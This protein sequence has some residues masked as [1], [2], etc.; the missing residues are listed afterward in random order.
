MRFLPI[1]FVA[2]I[3][4][5]TCA[6]QSSDQLWGQRETLAKELGQQL[7]E[8]KK[9]C[10][11][12]RADAS[13]AE[14]LAIKRD[15]QRQYIFLPTETGLKSDPSPAEAKL[16][17]IRKSHAVKLF[18]LAKKQS[19]AKNA[20][21][22]Y[23]LLHEAL[24]FDP[25]HAE[26]RKILG[27]RK[28]T[29][30]KTNWNVSSD[31]LRLRKS[32]RENSEFKWPKKSYWLASTAHFEITSRA[33]EKATRELAVKLER[34]HSVWRQVF[35][36]YWSKAS[37]LER[38][39]NGKGSA[40]VPSKKF[41]VVF[42]ADKQEYVKELSRAV[43]GI[44]VSSGY[45]VDRN[46]K[47]YFYAG[48]QQIED[49]W[50]HE[51]TH[52]LFSET[53]RTVKSPFEQQFLWLGEG[54][55]MYFESMVENE[56][57]ITLGGFDS[58]RMQFARRRCLKEQY[59][60]PLEQL[61]SANQKEFQTHPDR[62]RIYSQSAGVAHFL[63]NSQN[64]DLQRPLSEFLKLCYQGKLKPNSFAR[65]LGKSFDQLDKDYRDF[66]KVTPNQVANHLNAP[67]VRTEMA[68]PITKLT[69]DDF[70]ALGKCENLTWL[71]LSATNLQGKRLNHLTGCKNLQQLF[72]T[73]CIIDT[74]SINAI[75]SITSLQEL[76]LSG[77]NLTDE[78]LLQ[79]AALKKLQTI[80]AI[81]TKITAA[82]IAQLK[83]K[84]PSLNVIDR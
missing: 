37:V 23:Q 78:Q 50:R 12:S 71:D 29:D 67:H 16:Q 52:Q 10:E 22:A 38:W 66:L 63:M 44:E 77:S 26:V 31:R 15:P 20:S 42:F 36:D 69:E 1:L 32:T 6:A 9:W 43:P 75:S 68:I 53:T 72:L 57:Y 11:K 39:I 46:K 73:G 8:F 55:A 62:A 76:D 83:T 61:S 34:W 65:V 41:R 5:S 60:V 80:N 18:E 81:G 28:S 17:K 19:D 35:F 30:D 56:S 25:D 48:D 45:Y 58:R 33:D 74:D 70:R 13:A 49:T 82:G 40:R 59:F 7:D 24:Y 3:A 84:S 14:S 47:S 79:L 2:F 51:L 21:F 4:A 64:G 27:H 54:I